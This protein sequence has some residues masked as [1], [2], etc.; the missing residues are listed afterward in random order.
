M[1][2]LGFPLKIRDDILPSKLDIYNHLLYLSTEKCKS[3]EWKRNTDFNLKVKCVRDDVAELWDKTGIVHGL[4][5]REGEK[6]ISYLLTMCKN[7]FKVPMAR[8]QEGFSL[9]L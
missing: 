4:A 3:G 2:S 8:R 5:G 7:T 1:T 6:R 9:E